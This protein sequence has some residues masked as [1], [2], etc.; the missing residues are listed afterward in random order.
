M[1]SEPIQHIDQ[2]SSETD[3]HCHVADRIFQDQ[4]P[5]DDPGN[6]LAHSGIRVRVRAARDRNH[7]SQFRVTQSGE[8]TN[9]RNQNQR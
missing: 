9:G 1:P 2:V 3:T 5:A 7:G 6:Q 8:G 4:I